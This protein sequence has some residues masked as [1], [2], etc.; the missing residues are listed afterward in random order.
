ML[1]LALAGLTLNSAAK[2]ANGQANEWTWWGGSDTQQQPG[3]YGALGVPALGN[4]P[5]GRFGA[6][7]WTDRDGNLWL[8]GGSGFD[9]QADSNTNLAIHSGYLNDV[10]E[11]SPTTKEWTWM[12]GLSQMPGFKCCTGTEY[13]AVAVYGTLDQPAAENTPGG[14]TEAAHWV[15]SNGRLWLFGGIGLYHQ[16][17]PF[18]LSSHSLWFNDLWSF[19]PKT[20][21]WTWMGGNNTVPANRVLPGTYGTL[22]VPSA[23]NLPGARFDALTWVDNQGR[24]WLFGGFGWDSAGNVG[25][26]NDLW[27]FDPSTKQWAWIG[28]AS[29][30]G[31]TTGAGGTDGEPTVY[32]S[33]G[34][35]APGN[36]PGGRRG[37]VGWTDGSGNLWL[38]GGDG[39]AVSPRVGSLD[40]VWKYSIA[41]NEWT[42]EGGIQDSE[43]PAVP[44]TLGVPAAVNLPS[45]RM[46]PV[47]WKDSAGDFWVFSGLGSDYDTWRGDFNSIWMFN[48][49]TIQ[50]TWMGGYNLFYATVTGPSSLGTLGVTLPGNIPHGRIWGS[51]WNDQQGHFWLFGGFDDQ[52]TDTNTFADL[53]EYEPS[54]NTLPPVPVPTIFPPSGRRLGLSS[55]VLPVDLFEEMKQAKIYYTTDGT[56]P[57]SSSNLST[58]H[59]Q[60]PY[61]GP[62]APMTIIIK[63]IAIAEGYPDSGV[64]SASYTIAPFTA[65]PSFSP[66]SGTY[67]SPQ[68]V[69]MT[70]TTP[71]AKIFYTTDKSDPTANSAP[72]TAPVLVDHTELLSAVAVAP[73]YGTSQAYSTGYT[74]T[75]GF[76]LNSSSSSLTIS[77]GSKSDVTLTIAPYSGFSSAVTLG[78]SGLPAGV[79]CSFNPATVTPSNGTDTTTTL[80]IAASASA[81]VRQSSSPWLPASAVTLAALLFWWRPRRRTSVWLAM[82]VAWLGLSLISACGGGGPSNS[83]GTGGGGSGGGTSPTP[84]VS[85]VTITGT[86]GTLQASTMLTLT[87]N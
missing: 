79:T 12:A 75:P 35:A 29:N 39:V 27:C 8:F 25:L 72:Y 15:D 44:G 6:I 87:L 60:I 52:S 80:T 20:D 83:G 14:R 54:P 64:A 30:I 73:G 38:F 57:T 21:Q 28:G 24:F 10:W 61:A 86:A 58:T 32:G 23:T 78:C 45:G 68:M 65:S 3:T 55:P 19:D 62:I 36:T 46:L 13:G 43:R 77:P 41:N 53:W 70:T 74:I 69:T 49:S 16:D 26:L 81:A 4:R 59:G 66:N 1:V 63:A 37:A 84:T 9:S 82:L 51:G 2:F 48:P 85:T 50:W 22:G 56:I 71:G 11:Y 76:T 31:N 18:G 67:S 7:T 5:G 17:A 47:G 33:F 40:D 34:V 42:W